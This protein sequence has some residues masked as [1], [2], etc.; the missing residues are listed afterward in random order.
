MLFLKISQCFY[1][2]DKNCEH[3]ELI[4]WAFLTYI[5]TEIICMCLF[6]LMCT[7]LYKKATIL[8]FLCT[9]VCSHCVCSHVGGA[10]CVYTCGEGAHVFVHMCQGA[11]AHVCVWV[12][13]KNIDTRCLYPSPPHIL[14][15]GFL[16]H[17]FS[18]SWLVSLPQGPLVSTSYVLGIHMNHHTCTASAYI[19]GD[20]ISSPHDCKTSTIVTEALPMLR[21]YLSVF[22]LRTLFFPYY[23]ISGRANHLRAIPTW[24]GQGHFNGSNHAEEESWKLSFSPFLCWIFSTLLISSSGTDKDCHDLENQNEVSFLL[25]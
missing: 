17:L 14:W 9:C 20:L 3:F 5:H 11:H 22:L 24:D 19:A 25:L 2:S 6:V 13:R 15:Q 4:C 7:L 10:L 1:T 23:A 8:W 18:S 21:F 16:A 12:L